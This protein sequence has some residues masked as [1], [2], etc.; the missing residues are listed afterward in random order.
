MGDFG[1]GSMLGMLDDGALLS[2][3]AEVNEPGP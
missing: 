1:N 2:Q 3:M